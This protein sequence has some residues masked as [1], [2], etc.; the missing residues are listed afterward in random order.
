MTVSLLPILLVD[1]VGSVLMIVLSFLCLFK[2]RTIKVREPDQL[3]WT[4]LLWVCIGLAAFSLS[5]SAGHILK[6]I[7]ILSDQGVVWKT[8]SPYSGAVNT[9]MFVL[10]G[11]ITLF[12]EQ[13][14]SIHQE[15]R[16]DRKALRTTRDE[17]LY[18]NQNLESLVTERTK[19]LSASEQKHR[20]IFELSKDMILVAGKAGHIMDINPV[21]CD[22]LGCKGCGEVIGTTFQSH[23]L[24]QADWFGVM[25]AIEENGEVL[26]AEIDLKRSDGST[27]RTLLTGSLDKG[28]GIAEGTVHFLVKDIENRRLMKEQIAQAD[29]LASIGELSAG[30]A[31][32]I[33]NPLG[34]ILGYTQLLLRGEPAD[35]ERHDDLKTIE[36][37]VKNC[38]SIV[39][40]LLNFARSSKSEKDLVN[41]RDVLDDV[42][43]FIQQHSRADELAIEKIYDPA[44]P[45]IFVDE[46]KLRQVFMNLIMNARYAIED[47]GAI[48]LETRYDAGENLAFVKVADTGKGIEA[49][50]LSRIFDPFF[51]TKPTGKGTGL[52]LSV[53]YG[54]VKSHGGQIQVESTP[55]RG[56]VF[57][58]VL[59]VHS[60]K[61]GDR[62]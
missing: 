60:G 1:L 5:R 16:A 23:F 56:S 15:I 50:D 28:P 41:I 25:A 42:V 52:G 33:N 13:V 11:S 51:T 10:V 58:V 29:K 19:E 43:G 59:P 27:F 45:Q 14:W 9:A 39:E 17:L 4:Y 44:L 61:P 30:I 48:R 49:K 40:D 20:N 32:E 55:G 2:V 35:T 8:I 37:H 46:K 12:F 31:H 26:N 36:K 18:L 53:S 54:I 38:K 24:Q 34:I 57:T 6:Q 3:I 62:I 21:G 47:R 7:L 22:L